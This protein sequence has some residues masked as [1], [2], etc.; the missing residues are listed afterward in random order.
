[1]R[2]S[3]LKE[4]FDFEYDNTN[5]QGLFFPKGEETSKEELL[6]FLKKVGMS[7]K[8]IRSCLVSA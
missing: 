3:I 1:M 6:A 4:E 2:S 8:K 5:L 7:D